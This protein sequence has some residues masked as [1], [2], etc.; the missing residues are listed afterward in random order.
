ML[1]VDIKDPDEPAHLC[2]LAS[3]SFLSQ[4]YVSVPE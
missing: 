2:S 4:V 1:Y 3:Q